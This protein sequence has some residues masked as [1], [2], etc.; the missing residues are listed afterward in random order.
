[1]QIVLSHATAF[2][3]WRSF[4]GKVSALPHAVLPSG[5]DSRP[6]LTSELQGELAA[7]G[8]KISESK[9]I[10]CMIAENNNCSKTANIHCHWTAQPL[11]DGAILRISPNVSVVSP[12]LC[13]LQLA[14]SLPPGRLILAGTELC[15]T[16]ALTGAKDLESR[17][18]LTSGESLKRF[19]ELFVH[20][21]GARKAREAASHVFDGAASPMEAKLTL[22]LC[23]P[24]TLGGFGL[25][26]PVLNFP[27]PLKPEA[28][29]LYHVK[30]CRPDL[31]WKDA[32]LDVEYDGD[33]HEGEESHLKDTARVMALMAHG[34]D[35]I[36][37]TY[38]QLANPEAF[39]VSVEV[40][41][42]K[43]HHRVRIRV[44][45]FPERQAK[46]RKELEL[47]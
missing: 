37:L 31:Y 28:R 17:R 43:L 42:K 34:L 36:V 45:N 8:I 41:A 44:A 14:Q 21:S 10:H 19:A 27:I 3:Y 32:R 16:Y 25:P 20:V 39:R 11:P 40:I 15:G 46:L 22:L 13:F 12:E 47:G 38:P 18:P 1:M 5:P 30:T 24:A 9:A 26:R 4:T 29:A 33:T 23:L 2:L 35:V 6:K 7:L